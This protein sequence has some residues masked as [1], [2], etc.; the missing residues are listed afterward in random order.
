M[1]QPIRQSKECAVSL[2][3]IEA[4][5]NDVNTNSIELTQLLADFDEDSKALDAQN[6]LTRAS[7][8][9]GYMIS[10]RNQLLIYKRQSSLAGNAVAKDYLNELKVQMDGLKSI[11]YTYGAIYSALNETEK[12][13]QKL[14]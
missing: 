7:V 6:I 9:I 1:H 2:A 3:N 14:I 10:I 13:N 8:L 4:A 12:L 11:T 5:F